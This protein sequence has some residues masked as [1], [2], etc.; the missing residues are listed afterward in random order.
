[1]H[2]APFFIVQKRRVSGLYA[3][4]CTPNAVSCLSAVEVLIFPSYPGET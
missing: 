1:M 2:R 4:R 3:L